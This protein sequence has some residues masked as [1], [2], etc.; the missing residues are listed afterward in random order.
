[1]CMVPTSTWAPKTNFLL[2]GSRESKF[3]PVV[4]IGALTL[5]SVGEEEDQDCGRGGVCR[6][7]GTAG[8]ASIA[9]NVL[10]VFRMWLWY[11]IP[12][13]TIPLQRFGR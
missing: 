11:Y 13:I 1:M 6:G 7:W 8:W 9:A 2:E 12:Q 3:L 4:R 10:P 5:T